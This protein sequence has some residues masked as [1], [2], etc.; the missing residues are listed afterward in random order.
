MF[1]AL[2]AEAAKRQHHI[3]FAFWIFTLLR[4]PV[5]QVFSSSNP[6]KLK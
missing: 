5:L 6:E 1:T 3:L 4:F 2:Q